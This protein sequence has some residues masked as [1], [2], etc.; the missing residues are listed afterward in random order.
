MLTKLE[1]P[2]IKNTMDLIYPKL[3]LDTFRVKLRIHDLLFM[4]I[5]QNIIFTREIIEE[6]IKN[7]LDFLT[8]KDRIQ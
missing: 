4:P 2:T 7:L 8:S 5:A 3:P 1:M 6:H